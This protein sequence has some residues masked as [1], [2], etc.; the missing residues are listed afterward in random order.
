M[1]EV[2]EGLLEDSGE[3]CLRSGDFHAVSSLNHPRLPSLLIA[4]KFMGLRS[5]SRCV[6]ALFHLHKCWKNQEEEDI[7]GRRQ[8]QRGF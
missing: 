6:P 8:V 3:R 5:L 7:P 4:A 1:E 2:N